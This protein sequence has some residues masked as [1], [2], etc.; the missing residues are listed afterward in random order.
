[1][2]SEVVPGSRDRGTVRFIGSV[3]F[4]EDESE[5]FG[6]ELDTPVGRHDGTVQGIRSVESKYI[7]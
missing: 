7:P 3:D 1:M 5:W 4:V 2:V 6:V